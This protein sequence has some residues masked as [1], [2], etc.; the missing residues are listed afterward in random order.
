MVQGCSLS[1]ICSEVKKVEEAGLRVYTCSFVME[2]AL[3]ECCLQM[4]FVGISNSK[5]KLQK[6]IAVVCRWRLKSECSNGV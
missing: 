4:I 3:E 5:V 6:L 2:K 1:P